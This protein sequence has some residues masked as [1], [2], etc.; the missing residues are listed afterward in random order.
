MW[1]RYCKC[2]ISML[3]CWVRIY[4]LC[5]IFVQER[6]LS[7]QFDSTYFHYCCAVIYFLTNVMSQQLSNLDTAPSSLTFNFESIHVNSAFF[8]EVGWRSDLL[9]KRDGL[10]LLRD[11]PSL[12]VRKNFLQR[13]RCFEPKNSAIWLSSWK[14]K[15]NQVFSPLYWPIVGMA[16]SHSLEGRHMW[17]S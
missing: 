14:R 12:S 5:N 2:E 1:F 16:R 6:S 4:L 13:H 17:F 8:A 15:Q 10:D 11:L 9:L 3:M 7:V